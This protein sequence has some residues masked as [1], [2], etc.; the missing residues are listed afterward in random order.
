MAVADAAAAEAAE[1]ATLMTGAR[2]G[3]L[4]SL[5]QYL[6]LSVF[7]R[8]LLLVAKVAIIPRTTQ[9]NLAIENK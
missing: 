4:T 3:V 5:A 2:S 6:L 8:I 1:A 7:F 9:P